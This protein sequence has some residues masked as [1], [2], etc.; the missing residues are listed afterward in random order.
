MPCCFVR[1]AEIP[2]GTSTKIIDIRFLRRI[3]SCQ[4]KGP[5]LYQKVRTCFLSRSGCA[6]VIRPASGDQPQFWLSAHPAG[7]ANSLFLGALQVLQVLFER[8][9]VELCQKAGFDRGIEPTDVID[10]LTFVHV[11]FTFQNGLCNGL[12][13]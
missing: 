7:D 6:V 12:N 2:S 13:V 4:Q 9:L 10:E 3:E 8:F 5:S 1:P 11:V